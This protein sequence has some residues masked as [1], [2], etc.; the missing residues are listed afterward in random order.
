MLQANKITKINSETR[1]A[2]KN[3][4][5]IYY[6]ILDIIITSINSKFDENV[7]GIV[8]LMEKLF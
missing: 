1:C 4:I 2:K 5:N 3:E 7:I 8:I 6:A